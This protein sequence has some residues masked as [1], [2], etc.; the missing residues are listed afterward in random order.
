MDGGGC[1][2]SK[3]LGAHLP[4]LGHSR[5]SS[6]VLTIVALATMVMGGQALKFSG[7]DA[8]PRRAPSDRPLRVLLLGDSIMGQTG[9]QA[10]ALLQGY[11]A[12]VKI[13]AQWG[14]GLLSS[15]ADWIRRAADDV[16]TFDPDVAV[17]LFVGNYVAPYPLGADRRPIP[18]R[19]LAFYAAWQAKADALMTAL[20]ARGAAVW[21]AAPPPMANRDDDLHATGVYRAAAELAST[22]PG[23][24]LLDPGAAVAGPDRQWVG[25]VPDCAGDLDPVRDPDRL[26]LTTSGAQRMAAVLASSLA[27]VYDLAPLPGRAVVVNDRTV[28]IVGPPMRRPSTR[29]PVVPSVPQLVPETPPALEPA[30]APVAPAPSPEPPVT[31]PPEPPV[32]APP[33]SVPPA[34]EPTSPV[35]GPTTG[36]TTLPDPVPS[37]PS[38][39]PTTP[40][41]PTMPATS[42]MPTMPA[43]SSMPT[44][45]ATSTGMTG[46]ATP[47]TSTGMTGPATPSTSTGLTGPATPST[48]TGLTGPTTQTTPTTQTMPATQ[49]APTTPTSTA[50]ATAT[51]PALAQAAVPAS[52][53]P[54]PTSNPATVTPPPP[55]LP[56]PAAAPSAYVAAGATPAGETVDSAGLFPEGYRVVSCA[57]QVHAFG[58][59]VA[60]GSAPVRLVGPSVVGLAATPSGQG[61]WVVDERGAVT[62]FGDAAFFGAL[63]DQVLA[64]PIVGMAAS[65]SGLGYWLV[66]S[67]G[68][69]FAFGD[70]S[71]SGSTGAMALT[72]PI[73]GMAVTPTGLGYW[74]V[75]SDGGIFAFG[76][77]DFLGSAAA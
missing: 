42:T 10:V 13:D 50:S 75:A 51:V 40:T 61:Y 9:A 77:A 68:G 49:S 55:P 32:T 12:E 48:S 44:T 3:R 57:G 54:G 14:T 23:T 37:V 76:D 69:L 43:T 24:H 17:V 2:A 28:G 25:A 18:S 27:S 16:A 8:G 36:P 62:T 1:S 41:M 45:S 7:A 64:R 21:W 26:H 71:F 11:G 5:P 39:A 72:K 70:A 59:A 46:P 38:S 6:L 67:D 29:P 74:L 66:A 22:Y 33:D 58:A 47:S 52:A 34:P 60:A 56:A 19:S 35:T 63:A 73:V 31:A 65:P 20:T 53:L 4:R 30:P 15:D